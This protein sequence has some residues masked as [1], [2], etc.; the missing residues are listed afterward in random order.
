MDK[1]VCLEGLVNWALTQCRIEA[2]SFFL[3][4]G[5]SFSLFFYFLAGALV[6]NR[7][8]EQPARSYGFAEMTV[9]NSSAIQFTYR[10]T[11][12]GPDFPKDFYPTT[13]LIDEFWVFK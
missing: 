12:V 9:Y 4:G 8:E 1:V 7:W 10:G 5:A 3:G 13:G 6:N 2:A 11:T